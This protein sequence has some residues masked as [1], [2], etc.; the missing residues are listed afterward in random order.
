MKNT[1]A[2]S[3]A[4]VVIDSHW[5]AVESSATLSE[6]YRTGNAPEQVTSVIVTDNKPVAEQLWT[7]SA[8]VPPKLLRKGL[9]DPPSDR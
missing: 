7:A 8:C 9:P 5:P 4:G 2:D 6:L 1:L 3:L